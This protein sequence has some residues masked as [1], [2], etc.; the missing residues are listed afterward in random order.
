MPSTAHRGWCRFNL[1]ACSAVGN[2]RCSASSA[3]LPDCHPGAQGE[4]APGLATPLLRP[5]AEDT[6]PA[7]GGRHLLNVN[8][9]HSRQNKCRQRWLWCCRER[10]RAGKHIFV[11]R[12]CLKSKQN[13]CLWLSS[14]SP[15]AASAR[16]EVPLVAPGLIFLFSLV[17]VVVDS[18]P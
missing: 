17:V 8:K 3:I 13:C 14:N 18:F 4:P 10:G 12:I 2:A 5:L 7:R 9:N 15:A 11:H 16:H 6:D 1:G